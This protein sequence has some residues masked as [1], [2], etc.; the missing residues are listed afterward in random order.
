MSAYNLGKNCNFQMFALW[1]RKTPQQ[2]LKDNQRALNKT[3]RDLDRER[4]KLE[5]QEKKLIM[6]IKKAAKN[7][8]IYYYLI[9]GTNGCL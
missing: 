8:T 5:T 2:L 6:D 7:V 1:Q 3:G 9:A 4:G